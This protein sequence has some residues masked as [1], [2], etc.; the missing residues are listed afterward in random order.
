MKVDGRGGRA[1]ARR[2]D[3]RA[4]T[5]SRVDG[6]PRRRRHRAH[7]DRPPQ[8]GRLHHDAR[9]SGRP[10][11]RVRPARRRSRPG[12]SR[13]AASTGT[14]RACSFSRTTIGSG[15]R[16]TD[17]EAHVPKTL[18]RARARRA[19][20]RRRSRALREGVPLGDGT[21]SR[22]AEVRA[23]GTA[24]ERD[25]LAGDRPH[26]G[27]EPPG[28]PDVRAPSATTSSSSCASR[29][30]ASSSATSRRRVAQLGRGDRPA[31]LDAGARR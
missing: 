3:P 28:A 27:Q 24:R 9:R 7:G 25:E 6:R 5:R 23:L 14:A 26:R 20:R 29:S 11:H 16:L 13:W 4:A 18:P 12:C 19:R 21:V 2:I 22:P 31:A 30:A 17:P 1:P 10:P 8:A 15:Q